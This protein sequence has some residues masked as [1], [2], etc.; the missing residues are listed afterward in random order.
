MIHTA[1]ATARRTRL[2]PDQESS[3]TSPGR[4]PMIQ[5]SPATQPAPL[6]DSIL[7]SIAEAYAA[8]NSPLGEVLLSQALDDE[9]PW[10]EV[11]AAAA[12]GVARRFDESL[13]G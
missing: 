3:Q 2:R 10:N 5:A 13:D 1:R 11:C 7:D 8:G 12:R 6:F 9:L 4:L